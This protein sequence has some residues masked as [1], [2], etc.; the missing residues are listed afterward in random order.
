[1]N[2][3]RQSGGVVSDYTFSHSA[4]AIIDSLR[5]RVH[6]YVI[7]LLEQSCELL[8]FLRSSTERLAAA[9]LAEVPC[10]FEEELLLCCLRM[11]RPQPAVRVPSR[12]KARFTIGE[13][14]T[15][16]GLQKMFLEV[17][18]VFF[19]LADLENQFNQLLFLYS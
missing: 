2:L 13:F 17:S 7:S 9:P 3:T 4:V 8:H 16:F 12:E 18:K 14:G 1:L 15:L 5:G 11:L 10:W 19:L 6:I